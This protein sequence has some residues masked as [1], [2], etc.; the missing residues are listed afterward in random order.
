MGVTLIVHTIPSYAGVRLDGGTRLLSPVT[1][2]QTEGSHT[3]VIDKE[4]FQTITDTR[5]W[6]HDD[7]SLTFT[8]V[9]VG[10][11][12]AEPDE[13]TY[14]VYVKNR[15]SGQSISGAAVSIDGVGTRQTG[16]DGKANFTLR[17][18][19][20]VARV[21]AT[22]FNSTTINLNY[23]QAPTTVTATISLSPAPPEPPATGEIRVRVLDGNQ[24]PFPGVPVQVGITMKTTGSDG[25]VSFPGETPGSHNV[26]ATKQGFIGQ[27]RSVNVPANGYVSIDIFLLPVEEEMPLPGEPGFAEFLRSTIVPI[28]QGQFALPGTILTYLE[29]NFNAFIEYFID[30]PDELDLIGGPAGLLFLFIPLGTSSKLKTTAKVGQKILPLS[31]GVINNSADDIIALARSTPKTILDAFKA[32]TTTQKT[33]LHKNLLR[34]GRRG[35]DASDAVLAIT[36]DNVTTKKGVFETLIRE[37][38]TIVG[39]AGLIAGI[40]TMLVW[41]NMD[42]VPFLLRDPVDRAIRDGRLDEAQTSLNWWKFVTENVSSL[43]VDFSV[44]N[45]ITFGAF[46]QS[47][48]AVNQEI[49][50]FQADIDNARGEEQQPDEPGEE[51]R[52]TFTVEPEVFELALPPY[53]QTAISPM[54]LFV[55]PANYSGKISAPGFEEFSFNI[56]DNQFPNAAV[57]VALTPLEEEIPD[58]QGNITYHAVNN[59]TGEQ[60]FV[61]WFVDEAIVKS[62]S[63]FLEIVKP[64][65]TAIEVEAKK[66]GYTTA[67][68]VIVLNQG[69]NPTQ[70]LR[71]QALLPEE[72]GP[73]PKGLLKVVS[74]VPAIITI[75]GQPQKTTP[76]QFELD[77]GTYQISAR[78][79]TNP[80][81]YAPQSVKTAF[82]SVGETTTIS[83][84]FERVDAPTQPPTTST[85]ILRIE[86]FP[87]AKVEIAAETMSETTPI[88]LNL[89]PGQYDVV[90][91]APG[92][93]TEIRRTFI[94]VGETAVIS[95]VLT[96]LPLEEA[97]ELKTFID[98]ASNPSGAKIVINGGF[99]GK[100]TS[101]RI[102][103]KAGDYNLRL[104]KDG[105]IPFETVITIEEL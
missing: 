44:P 99:T 6:K 100:W 27:T 4:G 30:L 76:A 80:E 85:G 78:P 95:E 46:G 71:L 60:I 18:G 29:T 103:L 90:L 36:W 33:E 58:D 14:R 59:A 34:Q 63:S 54:T 10:D 87:S 16:S 37:W 81:L 77:A 64:A 50:A 13:G 21:S 42:N 31:E 62:S 102:F 101:D 11:E 72:G 93:Q 61:D 39:I 28:I 49:I 69:P 53:S 19:N 7:T 84:T 94:N 8:L 86:T 97:P 83:L 66:D 74:D 20:Y 70:T 75:T 3:L 88:D 73:Q 38:K 68:D 2:G 9:P 56:F 52:I 45:A 51:P 92:F 24:N 89:L 79:E 43:I 32:L 22:G 65:G 1:Y 5:N 67:L 23:T 40:N 25:R 35:L 26:T 91:S 12:P 96:E 15:E 55:P 105:F 41:F 98:I 104:E 82:V 47:F 57:N 48:D 17:N